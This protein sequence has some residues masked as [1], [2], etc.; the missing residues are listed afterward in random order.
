MER[1]APILEGM[2]VQDNWAV[3]GSALIVLGI[4]VFLAYAG[5]RIANRVVLRLMRRFILSNQ[6][7]WD[8]KLLE[9]KVFSRFSHVVPALV[10]Y[11]SAA[12]IPQFQSWIERVAIVYLLA[13]LA[14]TFSAFLNA[15]DAIYRTY[16]VSREKPIKGYLQVIKV[17]V[18][19]VATIL[20]V[21]NLIGKN[22]LIILSGLGALAAVLSFVFKDSLMGLVAG[23]QLTANDMV[24]LGDWIEM[25]RYGADGDVIDITLNT[26]K[27]QNFDRTIV[28]IPTY[29][30]VS[31]SFKNWRGIQA[32]GGRRIAREVHL[33]VTSVA[34]CTEG[35]LEEFKKIR[36]LREYI[37]TR[38]AEIDR[39]NEERGLA[40]DG[41]PVN[42]RRMTNLGV[43]R[44][45]LT[46]Y[47]DEHPR[48]NHSLTRMIRQMP[49]GETGLPMQI[50]CFTD[51]IEWVPYEGIQADIFDHVLAVVPHFGLRLYQ[52]PSGEDLRHLGISLEAPA[53]IP[54]FLRGAD[55]PAEPGQG[56]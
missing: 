54:A 47:L 52:Q 33:D 46:R 27:V 6:F 55:G 21:A 49:P 18:F 22:P 4:V 12:G 31:D 44:A 32:A 34:F 38:Q 16:E 15:V 26:V 41:S 35:Q 8:N 7:T 43:F 56:G 23:I 42:G 3:W 5:H 28:T 13:V 40:G 53:E 48:V 1:I 19:T 2:G 17:V 45:Y 37:E 10:I 51:T 11:T 9:H 14:M 30:L 29:A 20:I 25:P 36:L 50:Y 39:Y 24:R